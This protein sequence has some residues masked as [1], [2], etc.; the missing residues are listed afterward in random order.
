MNDAQLALYDPA[1]GG[2]RDGLPP[3]AV[4]ENQGAESTLAA[5]STL[6]LALEPVAVGA[7]ERFGP[8]RR[9]CGGPRRCSVPILAGW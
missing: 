5:L 7:S 3:T 1:T 4:N 6:Q 9:S 2:G 8:R